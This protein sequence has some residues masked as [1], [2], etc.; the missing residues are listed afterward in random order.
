MNLM[1]KLLQHKN[2]FLRNLA[3]HQYEK[4]PSGLYFHRAR[5]L[6]GGVFS[7][8]VD[9]GPM[10]LASNTPTNEG[11]NDVL[12]VYMKQSAQR[13]A[14]Y[15]VPYSNNVAPDVTITA[16]NFN[17]TLAE[18]INYTELSRQQWIGGA[19]A[20]ESV[21]NTASTAQII[22]GTGGGTIYGCG[23]STASAKSA[24]TGVMPFVAAFDDGAAVLNAGSK[25]NLEYTL[26]ATSG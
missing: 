22:I 5:I 16:A 1:Q 11:L 18:F 15:F 25:L 8:S 7:Y 14:F 24:T 13:A 23:L 2:E 19:V 20:S 26:G 4:S 3:N 9:E 17:A 10:H 6:I 12:A 21:D